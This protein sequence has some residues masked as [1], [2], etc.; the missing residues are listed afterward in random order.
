MKEFS[1]KSSVDMT[2]E[3][4]RFL[5]RL[6]KTACSQ[7]IKPWRD[8]CDR[9]DK[10]YTKIIERLAE[11]NRLAIQSKQNEVAKG[12]SGMPASEPA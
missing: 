4:E 12:L 3:D 9:K 1:R 5:A 11:E 2:L 8:E 10:E 7:M 6:I